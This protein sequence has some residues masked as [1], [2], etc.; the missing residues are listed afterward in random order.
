MVTPPIQDVS[1]LEVSSPT[2]LLTNTDEVEDNIDV[3]L[4][5]DCDMRSSLPFRQEAVTEERESPED[6]NSPYMPGNNL[7]DEDEAASTQEPGYETGDSGYE[8]RAFVGNY[9]PQE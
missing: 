9:E 4:P 3:P 8:R 1:V 7:D 5:S 2:P 6:V